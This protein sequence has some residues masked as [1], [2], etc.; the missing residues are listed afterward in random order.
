MSSRC[1]FKPS[2]RC[3]LAEGS[4]TLLAVFPAEIEGAPAEAAGRLIGGVGCKSRLFPRARKP[5]LRRRCIR[6]AMR[7]NRLSLSDLGSAQMTEGTPLGKLQAA[8]WARGHAGH[9]AFH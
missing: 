4:S 8:L 2:G 1:G 6:F 7:S 9:T 5:E 3:G